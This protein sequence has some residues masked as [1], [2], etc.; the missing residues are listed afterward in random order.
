MKSTKFTCMILTAVFAVW[1]TPARLAAQVQQGHKKGHDGYTVTNL[2]TLGGTSSVANG[3][4]NKGWITGSA[5]LA[6]DQT[7]HAFLW[8]KHKGMTDLGTLGGPNSNVPWPVKDNRG[9][10]AGVSDT[11]NTDPLN[12][13]FCGSG[14]GL[15][16][17]GFV[18]QN[19]TMTALPTLGGN[20]GAA[21]AANNRGQVVGFAETSTQDPNCAPPQ[22]LIWHAVIWGPKPGQIQELP[23]LSG[24][25]IAG[26]IAIND[27][28]QA[29]GG[30]GPCAPVHP[31]THALLWQN[32][33][34]MDLGNL[35]GP[36]FN[37]ATGINERGDVIGISDLAGDVYEDAFL[38][39]KDKGMQDL[40]TLPGDVV[41]VA[42]GIN[43][44]GQV[45]G[46]S[47]D[48]SGNCRA[49]LW[50]DGVMTD[51]NTLVC[52]GTSL[53]LTNN[54][55]ADINDRGEIVGQAY[56]PSTG[57]T[58]AYLAV[59]SHGEG[60]CEAGASAGQKVILPEKVRERLQQRRGFGRFGA[61]LMRPQ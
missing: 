24:D 34:P 57:D 50:Q 3:I 44:K 48:A 7:V 58:P 9:L 26:A 37:I 35:G 5:N 52:P 42:D 56:D 21:A 39:T 46:D 41:S 4:N 23:P 51:L 38:W 1:A 49:F 2:G 27:K 6:G 14:N 19:G 8:T 61:A 28:G 10:I 22:V 60:H 16:C 59:P 45:V 53:Y 11:S 55:G 15:I 13:N 20:N 32:G 33:V 12:E 43:N 40:G 47:C 54:L 17:L 30:S 29:V 31:G 18:W 25:V 36:L